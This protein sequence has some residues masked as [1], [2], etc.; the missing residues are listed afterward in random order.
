[1]RFNL[2]LVLLWTAYAAVLLGIIRFET[3]DPNDESFTWIM[4]PL[5]LLVTLLIIY[6]SARAK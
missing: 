2:K 6:Q 5:L 1:M 4:L 3:F